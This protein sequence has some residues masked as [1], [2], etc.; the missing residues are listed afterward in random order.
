LYEKRSRKMLMKLTA[1]VNFINIL[2]T[3][4]CMKELWAAFF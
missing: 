1:G 2:I 3:P 4:F